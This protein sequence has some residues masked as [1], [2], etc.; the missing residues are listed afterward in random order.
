MKFPTKIIGSILLWGLISGARAEETNSFFP[1]MAWNW[2]SSD[3]AVYQ[4]MH[5]CGLTVAGFVPP[6]DLDLCQAAGLKAIVSDSRS[7]GYDWKKVDEQVARQNITSLVAEVG[8]HPALFGFYLVDEP[9]AAWFPGLGKVASLIH[10]QAPGKWAYI[11]LFPNY[12]S[13]EQLGTATYREHLEKFIELCQPTTLSYDHYALMDDGSLRHG[14]WQNLEQMRDASLKHGIPFW[15]IVLTVAHFN[16]REPTAGDLRFQVYSTLAYGGRG[17]AYFTYIAPSVGNY[18]MAPID[19]FGHPT[20]TWDE[21]RNVNLQVG[22]LAPTLL[23]L[24]SDEV[25]HFGK[26]P[27]ECRGPGDKSLVKSAA[28][29]IMVGDFTHSDGSRYVLAV[30]KDVTRSQHCDLHFRVAPKRIQHVSP[31]SGQLG[32]F[33]GEQLWLAPGQGVLLRLE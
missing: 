5:D 31:Y 10:Q 18:R 9:N 27:D 11:N 4:M 24:N 33:S 16:Y 2:S 22:K 6:K 30:N 15:N 25:Y 17:L 14:Y 32:D 28:G 29:E 21:L 7:S 8:K 3:P 13:A 19:Q 1:L 12:A 23:K 26:V 20:R